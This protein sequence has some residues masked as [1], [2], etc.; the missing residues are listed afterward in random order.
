[1]AEYVVCPIKTQVA[2]DPHYLRWVQFCESTCPFAHNTLV[3]DN[4]EI[5]DHF[6]ADSRRVLQERVGE[7]SSA[8][9]SYNNSMTPPPALHTGQAFF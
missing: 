3:C 5:E 4:K 9:E 6:P 2:G 8:W 1:M 7:V